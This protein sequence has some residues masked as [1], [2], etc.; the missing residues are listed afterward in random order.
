MILCATADQRRRLAVKGKALGRKRLDKTLKEHGMKPAPE[1]PSSWR[2]FIKSECLGKMSF[3]GVSSL[4]RAFRKYVEHYHDSVVR[5]ASAYFTSFTG[6]ALLM[7][8]NASGVA[9]TATAWLTVVPFQMGGRM[10]GGIVNFAVALP[11]ASRIPKEP[12]NGNEFGRLNVWT[13]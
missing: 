5:T 2:S 10:P 9:K 7:S 8:V 6:T 11:L 13:R 12:D 4:D 3:F 1:C